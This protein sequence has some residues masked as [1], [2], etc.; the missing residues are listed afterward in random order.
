MDQQND[1]QPFGVG[2]RPCAGRLLAWAEMWLIL[3]RL[4]W[5]FDLL[6]DD[7]EDGR[8]QWDQQ[9]TFTVLERQPFDVC[10]KRREGVA[11]MD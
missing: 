10:L 4:T 7:T 3:A 5:R 9:R 6:P 1:I 11:A 2:P 8:L